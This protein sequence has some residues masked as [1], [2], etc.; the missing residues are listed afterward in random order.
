MQDEVCREHDLVRRLWFEAGK[1]QG[2]DL[3][4]Y[5]VFTE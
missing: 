2:L 5:E 3:A 4:A 1:S